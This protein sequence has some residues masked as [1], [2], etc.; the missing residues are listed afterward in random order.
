MTREDLWVRYPQL[1]HVAFAAGWEGILRNGLWSAEELTR[2]LGW[3]QQ[4]REKWLARRR[5]EVGGFEDEQLGRVTFRDHK[6]IPKA[7]LGYAL[8]GVSESEWYREL[9][10]RVYFYVDRADADGLVAA[11]SEE[12]VILTVDTERLVRA[13]EDRVAVA[14]I[15]TGYALR[16]PARRG[17]DTFTAIRDFPADR[18]ARIAEFTVERGIEKMAEFT[19]TVERSTNGGR[20]ELWTRVP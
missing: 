19:T 12:Q 15:N 14:T 18:A 4:Q 9:N 20:E 3:P 17:L 16:R 1:F 6:A 5:Q 7:G 8:V 11:Y 13:C 10:R 2:L